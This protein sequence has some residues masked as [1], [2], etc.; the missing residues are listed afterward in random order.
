MRGT[1]GKEAATAAAKDRRS[2]LITSQLTRLAAV[3]V[4]QKIV[5]YILDSTNEKLNKQNTIDQLGYPITGHPA[6]SPPPLPPTFVRFSAFP[7]KI[8]NKTR[9]YA[10]LP[11]RSFRLKERL[12]HQLDKPMSISHRRYSHLLV[13]TQPSNFWKGPALS[14]RHQNGAS[15]EMLLAEAVAASKAPMDRHRRHPALSD[16]LL[17]LCLSQYAGVFWSRRIRS[18]RRLCTIE[19]RHSPHS[20]CY[21]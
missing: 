19:P 21:Q 8:Q 13:Q 15:A 2:L 5:Q 7:T 12:S 10:S 20:E 17:Q 3:G 16:K 1:G 18:E 6:P 14:T 11:K 9:S 4:W